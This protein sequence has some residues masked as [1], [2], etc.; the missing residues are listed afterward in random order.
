MDQPVTASAVGSSRKHITLDPDSPFVKFYLWFYDASPNRINTCK[1]FWAYALLL[2][3]VVPVVV[4]LVHG[5]GA[6]LAAYDKRFPRKPQPQPTILEL[7]ATRR[8]EQAEKQAKAKKGPSF[9]ERM[10]ER[11]SGSLSYFWAKFQKPI[12]WAFRILV[13]ALLVAAGAFAVYTIVVNWSEFIE[14]LWKFLALVVGTGFVLFLIIKAIEVLDRKGAFRSLK[15]RWRR[16]WART[17]QFYNLVHDH[18]CAI[19][20]LKDKR[21]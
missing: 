5:L 16:G 17:V 11:V 2:T 1:M 21:V 7:E 9:L 12:T 6:L 15:R 10:L 14:W 20:D 18:T 3:V 8:A 4:L 19:V 13:A